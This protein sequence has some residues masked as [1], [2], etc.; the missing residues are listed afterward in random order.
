MAS[1]THFSGIS[2]MCQGAGKRALVKGL[3]SLP[4]ALYG[5]LSAGYDTRFSS[6]H[7]YIKGVSKM[8]QEGL[9]AFHPQLR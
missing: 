1:V 7:T 4:W 3:V 5:V 6:F 9:G 8:I 2:D